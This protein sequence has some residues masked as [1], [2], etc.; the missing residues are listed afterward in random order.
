MFKAENDSATW[1]H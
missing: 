1:S